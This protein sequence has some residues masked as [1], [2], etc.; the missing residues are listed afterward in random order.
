[1]SQNMDIKSYKQ[2]QSS[3]CYCIPNEN[4]I[5]NE[6]KL[7]KSCNLIYIKE[8][9]LTALHGLEV[10]SELNRVEGYMLTLDFS[11]NPRLMSVNKFSLV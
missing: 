8:K 9:L 11:I 7:Q 6:V 5:N 2:Q 10:L 4:L 3:K 1:M